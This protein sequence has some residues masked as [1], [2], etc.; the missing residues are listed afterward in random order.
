MWP[1]CRTPLSTASRITPSSAPAHRP[2]IRRPPC[3]RRDSGPRRKPTP[4]NRN[5]AAAAKRWPRRRSSLEP[6]H[7]RSGRLTTPPTCLLSGDQAP[8]LPRNLHNPGSRSSLEPT[9]PHLKAIAQQAQSPPQDAR[10]QH[11]QSKA[12]APHTPQKSHPRS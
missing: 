11:L 8:R 10:K 12:E 9:K 4:A 3:V 5:S 6:G 2:S 7:K 1:A